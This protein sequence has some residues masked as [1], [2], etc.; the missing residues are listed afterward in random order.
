MR[1]LRNLTRGTVVA[2]HVEEAVRTFAR[3]KGLLGR[4]GLAEGHALLIAPCTSIHTFF[5]RF[6][7]DVVFLGQDGRALRVLRSLRPWRATR[8][9]PRAACVIEL[10]EGALARSGT[11]EGD[12]LMLVRS[13]DE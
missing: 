9:Y 6:T 2:G 7:I 4:D 12:E 3:L 8:I 10:V 1:A 11:E 5:M 13:D